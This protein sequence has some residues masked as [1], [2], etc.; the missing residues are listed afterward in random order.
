MPGERNQAIEL[1]TVAEAARLLK[2][3]VTGVRR[4]QQ[5]R[6]LPFIKVGGQV[7]FAAE[8]LLTYLE[9]RRVRSLGS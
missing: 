1:L 9:T 2:I 3:S 6:L 8:D 5:R 4:L 7:R